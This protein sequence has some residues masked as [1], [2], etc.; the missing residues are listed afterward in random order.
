MTTQGIKLLPE[1]IQLIPQG[2]NIEPKGILWLFRVLNQLRYVIIGSFSEDLKYNKY[3]KT[4]SLL[5][6]KM[7][8]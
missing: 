7:V 1:G 8:L 2:A 4:I 3:I 5:C 6:L